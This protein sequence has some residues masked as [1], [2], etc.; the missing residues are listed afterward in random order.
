MSTSVTEWEISDSHYCCVPWRSG[1]LT[2]QNH[3][4]LD[5]LQ[6]S[7]QAQQRQRQQSAVTVHGWAWS[8]WASKGGSASIAVVVQVDDLP[9]VTVPLANVSRPD[10]VAAGVA[11]N[12]THGFIISTNFE[13]KSNDDH[14]TVNAW[15]VPPQGEPFLLDSSPR[16]FANGAEVPC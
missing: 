12:A 7:S 9:N 10:L 5:P 13:E 15:G 1:C 14:H 11:P 8:E 2:K 16:C 4:I 3:G 6:I